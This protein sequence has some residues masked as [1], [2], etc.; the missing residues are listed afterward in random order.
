[1]SPK[2]EFRIWQLS[3]SNCNK[4]ILAILKPFFSR[5][6]LQGQKYVYEVRSQKIGTKWEISG[7]L[8]DIYLNITPDL[9]GK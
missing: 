6:K 5:L 7:F 3:F 9:R 1:M 8:L 2:V 4:Q